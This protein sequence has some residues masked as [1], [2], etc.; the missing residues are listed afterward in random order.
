ME[1][2]KGYTDAPSSK[3]LLK[4]GDYV[5]ALKKI[6]TTCDTPMTISITGEWGSGKTSFVHQLKGQLDKEKIEFVEFNTWEISQFE[7]NDNL[8]LSL[9]KSYVSEIAPDKKTA[10]LL[11]RVIRAGANVFLSTA[12]NKFPKLDFSNLDLEKLMK[13]ESI[14]G[15]SSIVQDVKELK[16]S[17]EAQIS[18]KKKR[19]VIFIDDLDRINPENA[20]EILEFLKLFLSMKNCVYLVAVDEKVIEEGLKAKY[21]N[22]DSAFSNSRNYFEKLIQLPFYLPNTLS[23]DEQIREYIGN[24]GEFNNV[25]GIDLNLVSKIVNSSVG[26][27][28]RRIKRIMNAYWLLRTMMDGKE[29][30]KKVKPELLF[31]IVCF[32]THYN[33][34]YSKFEASINQDVTIKKSI[35][36]LKNNEDNAEFLDF[37]LIL[38]KDFSKEISE[39]AIKSIMSFSQVNRTEIGNAGNLTEAMREL[40]P[41]L[42]D[43]DEKKT[44]QELWNELKKEFPTLNEKPGA[45]N[46]LLHR[47]NE[48]K[49]KAISNGEG[50]VL[51][52]DRSE[53][54]PTYHFVDPTTR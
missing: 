18:S 51:V 35:T 36:S 53:K 24:L 50:K 41:I 30:N 13:G 49:G 54:E 27:N 11:K 20:I 29:A 16:K 19:Y 33:G 17:I 45:F 39:E 28:P 31:Y 37:I 44:R 2:K 5:Q 47:V 12:L 9:L 48:G 25:R 15:E 32:Q 10:K 3:D 1:N 22:L 42:F 46:G 7:P 38:E 34:Q 40:I 14:H 52:R 43:S 21:K 23:N 8:K 4:R 26:G 6:V